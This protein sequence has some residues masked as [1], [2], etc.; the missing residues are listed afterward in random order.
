[1]IH[2]EKYFCPFL[3][4]CI[5]APCFVVI[6][7]FLVFSHWWKSSFPDLATSLL[8]ST[9]C[10]SLVACRMRKYMEIRLLLPICL[11][12][13][14]LGS[15]C[16]WVWV[17]TKN[18]TIRLGSEWAPSPQ[19]PVPQPSDP[20]QGW[21]I[22]KLPIAPQSNRM[23]THKNKVL[24]FLFSHNITTHLYT[25]ILNFYQSHTCRKFKVRQC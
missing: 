4:F 15:V 19:C 11:G 6:V 1:M 3:L 14:S 23:H 7:Y 5:T 25:L 9:K 13:W 21:Q 10:S 12:L 8:K 18:R 24:P 22:I 17:G 16:W 2:G 20:F